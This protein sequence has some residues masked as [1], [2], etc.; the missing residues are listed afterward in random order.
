[1]KE[2]GGSPSHSKNVTAQAADKQAP[3]NI[4]LDDRPNATKRTASKID[5]N[6]R[7]P[8]AKGFLHGNYVPGSKRTPH[9]S[10]TSRLEPSGHNQAPEGGSKRPDT[11]SSLFTMRHFNAERDLPIVYT[12]QYNISAIGLELLHQFDTK[13]YGKIALYLSGEFRDTPF[14]RKAQHE[15]GTQ[16]NG[17]VLHCLGPNRPVTRKELEIHHTAEFVERIH[18]DKSLVARITEIWA[19]NLLPAGSLESRL[20]IPIKWQIAGTIF[21]TY[22]AMQ[23]GWSI[24]LGGGFHQCSANQGETFCLFSDV[25][26]AIRHVWQRHP[27]QKFMIIDLDAH[28]GVGIERDILELEPKR[29]RMVFMVDIFNSAIQPPNEQADKA[30]DVR[31]ELGKFTGDETYLKR[32]D[33]ALSIA[34]EK[35]KPTVVI[36]IAGQDVLRD[37]QLG[38]M[39]L[40]D[41]GLKKRDELVFSSAVEKNCPIVMLLG[42]GYLDRGAKLQADSIR[43]LFAKGLIWGGHRS[44]ARSLSRPRLGQVATKTVTSSRIDSSL[45]TPKMDP[46]RPTNTAAKS[47]FS[48]TSIRPPARKLAETIRVA[49]VEAKFLL[50]KTAAN[51]QDNVK[52]R[53]KS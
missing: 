53:D 16:D 32:L 47:T 34:F 3:S 15:E 2:V 1:M 14:V 41:A 11:S 48:Q 19:L 43:N 37:D 38:L 49:P 8:L 27:L 7:L 20:L 25:F 23:H 4:G 5:I 30:I 12:D 24:N 52:K 28:Q 22:L 46:S 6:G 10:S 36:Y 42:G 33:E 17:V 35:F 45:V 26:V 29:R 50:K 18:E 21:A 9:Q 44:G 13:K 51:Q 39:N 31:V 40:S